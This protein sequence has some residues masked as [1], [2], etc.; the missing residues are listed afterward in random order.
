[1]PE[2]AAGELPPALEPAEEAAAQDA[3]TESEAD[4]SGD[5]RE[6]HLEVPGE[7]G[8]PE[9]ISPSA[10]EPATQAATEPVPD[11]PPS[12]EREP[13][14]EHRP[15]RAQHEQRRPEPRPWAKAA[16]FRPAEPSAISQAVAH[17][18]EIAES[19]KQTIDQLD[20]ILELVEIAERQKLA[21]EREIEE[22][23]R[24]LRR[25][26]PPRHQPQYASRGSRHD[27]P[28]RGYREQGPRHE[29][30]QAR[31]E[32]PENPQHPEEFRPPES[33]EMGPHTDPV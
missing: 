21:D 27:E 1:M 29:E 32:P 25:I 3:V 7:S 10:A 19:L 28:H 22:L 26:H 13:A 16:D 30:R 31:Q 5:F 24:A 15:E 14:R 12:Q 18:T 33:G 2:A 9:E 6:P 17:A 23:R 11:V 20:E 4:T 8:P